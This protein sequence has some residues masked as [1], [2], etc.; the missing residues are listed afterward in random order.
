MLASSVFIRELYNIFKE[1][2]IIILQ[3][4]EQGEK[5][6]NPFAEVRISLIQSS[7]N[8]LR[9]RKRKEKYFWWN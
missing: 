6:I 5:L 2:M 1:A 9:E 7:E 8:T 4:K 3:K